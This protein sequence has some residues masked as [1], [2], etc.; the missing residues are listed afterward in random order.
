M[1]REKRVPRAFRVAAALTLAALL[2]A[3]AGGMAQAGGNTTPG[4]SSYD[5]EINQAR[6]EQQ[7]QEQYAAD[8]ENAVN[9]TDRAIADATYKLQELND[10]LPVVQAEYQTAKDTYDAAVL[11]QQIVADKLAAAEAE[12]KNLTEQ[13]ASDEERIEEL[14]NILAQVARTEYQGSRTNTSLV[15][16]LGGQSSSEVV[17]EYA[18]AETTARVQSTTLADMEELAAVNRNRATR[19]EAVREYI[20]EL[21]AQADALV[22]ETE[23]AKQAAEDKKAE[24]EQLLQETEDLKA[25]LDQ[26]KAYYLDQQAKLEEQQAALKAELDTLWQKK[27]AEEAANGTGSL[28]KGFFSFPTAVPYI[29]SSFGYRIH[30]IFGTRILHEGTDFRAYCGTAIKAAADGK[31][32]WSKWQGGY[33]NQVLIDHGIMSNKVVYTNYNHLTSFAVSGGQNVKRGD[34]VGY[35]GNTGNSTACHLHFEVRLNGAAVNPMEYMPD[36]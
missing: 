16:I 17:D 30:P 3:L 24:V 4:W 15:V 5:D 1:N 31:V 25:Y 12:D 32:L 8:L 26:Q 34:I 9:A 20:E 33:G 19:Q 27:L 10:R 6:K 36:L 7:R 29:T 18:Y 11:Q 14:N 23:A 13:I 22:V 35:S 28:G 21:K 2:G